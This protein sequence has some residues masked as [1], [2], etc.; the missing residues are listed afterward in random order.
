MIF[1]KGVKLCRILEHI[2]LQTEGVDITV[3]KTGL[4]GYQ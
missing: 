2:E 3:K 1:K 4:K